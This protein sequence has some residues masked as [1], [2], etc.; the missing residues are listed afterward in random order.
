MCKNCP[1]LIWKALKE[2][3]VYLKFIGVHIYGYELLHK[4]IDRI[5]TLFSQ[6]M[7]VPDE[8]P[9]NYLYVYLIDMGLPEANLLDSDA[10]DKRKLSSLLNMNGKVLSIKPLA[11]DKLD[12]WWNTYDRK[13]TVE[14]K[15]K[16]EELNNNFYSNPKKSVFVG[17]VVEGICHAVGQTELSSYL[18]S[19]SQK[20]DYT[21]KYE[22]FRG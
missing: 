10:R 11:K 7:P 22:T 18:L 15:E 5:V 20:E 13:M 2:K 12:F 3:D 17:K 16:R 6:S 9:P 14:L 4:V 21:T 19:F 1:A 8:R